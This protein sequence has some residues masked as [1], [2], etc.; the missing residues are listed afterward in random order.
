MSDEN[1]RKFKGVWIRASLWLRTDLNWMQKCLLAE[2]DSLSP[3]YCSNE[4]LAKMM[5]ISESCVAN[6]IS[7]LRKKGLIL[8]VSFDGR[9]RVIK[10]SDSVASDYQNEE[11][12]VPAI[13][14]SNF[15]DSGTKNTSI[16]NKNSK[17]NKEDTAE[18]Q[19]VADCWN[20]HSILER[21]ER[22]TR[23]RCAAVS[24]RMKDPY[25]RE[26]YKSAIRRIAQSPFCCGENDRGWK[27][28]I[29]WFLKPDTITYVMEG[30]YDPKKSSA[31]KL[32][33][34]LKIRD[35]VVYDGGIPQYKLGSEDDRGQHWESE[36]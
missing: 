9:T 35:G 23:K 24:A 16:D 33:F 12:R 28:T 27:A 11:I 22:K 19:E 10:V 8:D 6:N 30:K 4:H 34:G 25:F 1:E 20:S 32:K 13:S 5:G 17:S 29:D 14:N 36:A 15:P 2:I 7:E 21:A 18:Y 26:N 31:K 3:C